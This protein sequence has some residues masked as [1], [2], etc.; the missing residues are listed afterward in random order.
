MKLKDKVLLKHTD[1]L[2][3]LLSV[4]LFGLGLIMI[5]SASNIAAFMRYN[6]SPYN[7]LFKQGASLLLGLIAFIIIIHF[8][9]K[10]YSGLSWLALVGSFG[11]LIFVYMF[12]P[13]IN[14]AKSWISLGPLGNFQPSEFVKVILIVWYA[15][16]FELK[17][18]VLNKLFTNFF[19]LIIS[20]LIAGLVILQ[21]DFGTA[22]IMMI[23]SFMLYFLM[24]VQRLIKAKVLAISLTVVVVVLGGYYIYNTSS[25]QRQLDRF[26][27]RYPCSEEKFYTTGNQVCNSYI[28]FNNG[29]MWGKGLGNSTQKYLYLPESHTD[30]IFAIVVEELGYFVSALVIIAFGVLLWRIIYIG[31][32]SVSSRG[33]IICYG[34]AIYIFLH[35][36]IN[37]MGIMGLLPLTGVPL[38]FLSYGGSFTLS[39]IV[40]LS[41]VQRVAIE[42]KLK[43]LEK[44][45]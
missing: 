27:Y 15:A 36:I 44:T 11:I 18:H 34:V 35:M 9:T 26:D 6:K 45:E 25:F 1:K 13:I 32:K 8:S 30:F 7:F 16:F 10:A 43:K 21:P 5:F 19:P 29:G 4:L 20:A 28:A 38:P 17:R 39:L 2:L 3:L 23:L 41:M 22:A 31:N 42:T 37:L 24:P 40:A 14:D 33:S 12:G